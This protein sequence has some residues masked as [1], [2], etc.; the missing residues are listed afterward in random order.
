MSGWTWLWMLGTA[1]EPALP[2]QPGAPDHVCR[3]SVPSSG[4]SPL[5]SSPV[6]APRLCLGKRGRAGKKKCRSFD[7]QSSPGWW[8][9]PCSPVSGPAGCQAERPRVWAITSGR[10]LL[11]LGDLGKWHPSGWGRLVGGSA[12]PTGLCGS[13]ISQSTPGPALGAGDRGGLFPSPSG[14][15]WPENASK[16]GCCGRCLPEPECVCPGEA[17]GS[18]QTGAVAAGG[19]AFYPRLLK[20]RARK[21]Q[22]NTGEHSRPWS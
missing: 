15:P 2:L 8:G 19:A 11:L 7:G 16:S 6:R 1:R 3:T 22:R 21:P 12:G 18:A 4:S 9:N 10:F 13:S 5:T 14:T 17:R 20:V